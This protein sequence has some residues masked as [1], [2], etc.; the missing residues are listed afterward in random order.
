MSYSDQIKSKNH[1][2][3]KAIFIFLILI[4]L[5][6]VTVFYAKYSSAK[7]VNIALDSSNLKSSG[8]QIKSIDTQVVSK[9]WGEIDPEKVKEQIKTIK[10]LGVN[11]IAISTPY[12]DPELMKVWVDEIHHQGLNVWF[13]SHWLNWEGDDNHPSDMTMAEY[14][15]KTKEFIKSHPSYFHEGDA[16]TVC[17]E[18][19]Q[20]FTARDTDVY[21][22]YSYN[23]FLI[24]QIDI[25]NA[26]FAD[27]ELAG[28]IHTNWISMN[29]WVVENGLTQEAVDKMGLITVDHYSNQKVILPPGV[30]AD[31]LGA[32]LDRMYQKWQKPILLGEWGYNIEQEVTDFDQREVVRESLSVLNGKKYL[33][34]LNYWAH[35]G[36]SS[37]IINDKDGTNLSYRPAAIILRDF[38]NKK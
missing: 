14:L 18:P 22:W 1:K 13:R 5:T 31:H 8:I 6:V 27:I 28:K 36:N 12:D 11:Y 26:A 20:V 17:V 19:E 38:Y 34:G 33:V 23:K 3:Y 37:R 16:F 21:D 35:M 32:D 9:H 7:S 24:D 15:S 4:I 10:D 30:V 25:A 29:G 2:N